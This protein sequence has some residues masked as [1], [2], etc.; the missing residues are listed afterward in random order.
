MCHGQK[1]HDRIRQGI[2]IE[3]SHGLDPDCVKT[4]RRRNLRELRFKS[5]RLAGNL[6][7]LKGHLTTWRKNILCCLRVLEFSHSLVRF[8]LGDILESDHRKVS[9]KF[10]KDALTITKM[11]NGD[12]TIAN[13]LQEQ[14]KHIDDM[15]VYQPVDKVCPGRIG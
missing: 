6:P 12:H 4:N 13:Y 9:N 7:A 5:L 15:T 2:P 1:Y 8:A 11:T 3:F 14:Y 10:E